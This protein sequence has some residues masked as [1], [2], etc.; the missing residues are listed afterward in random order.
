MTAAV[1]QDRH[2]ATMKKV[3]VKSLQIQTLEKQKEVGS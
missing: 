3:A 2:P 1:G